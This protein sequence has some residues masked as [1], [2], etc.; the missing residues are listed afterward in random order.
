M[1]MGWDNGEDAAELFWESKDKEAFDRWWDSERGGKPLNEDHIS[2][3]EKQLY[4]WENEAWQAA[5]AYR[6]KQIELSQKGACP[7]CEPIGELNLKLSNE[8]SEIK[9]KLSDIIS[10]E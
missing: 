7:T 2:V 4:N 5:L 6:D 1:S 10:G 8:L 3:T 9:S